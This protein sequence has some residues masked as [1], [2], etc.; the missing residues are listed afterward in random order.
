[1]SKTYR[2]SVAWHQWHQHH[3]NRPNDERRNIVVT[4]QFQQEY[5]SAEHVALNDETI[6]NTG[7]IPEMGLHILR[8]SN[9][10]IDAWFDA[11]SGATGWNPV[12]YRPT[13]V[14]AQTSRPRV[15]SADTTMS[16]LRYGRSS[17][18]GLSP[19]PALL[20][21]TRYRMKFDKHLLLTVSNATSRLIF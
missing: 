5:S 20:H 2:P 1:M 18:N 14:A 9:V 12:P 21:G 3:Q 11:G 13:S 19:M 10:G 4:R 17:E 16:N 8:D 15:R 7:T 6:T